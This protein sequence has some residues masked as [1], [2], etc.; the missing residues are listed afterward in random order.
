VGEHSQTADAQRGRSKDFVGV[1]ADRW[2][3]EALR[4][5]PSISMVLLIGGALLENLR[6]SAVFPGQVHLFQT[7][8]RCMN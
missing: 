7:L 3:H 5:A 8:N 1:L 2:G 4:R 6:L